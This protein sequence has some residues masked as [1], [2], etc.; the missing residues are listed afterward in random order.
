MSKKV[1]DK[2]AL[3]TSQLS[4]ELEMLVD[5]LQEEDPRL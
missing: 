3:I 4:S 1:D 5:W 2:L